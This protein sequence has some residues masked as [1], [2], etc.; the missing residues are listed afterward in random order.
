MADSVDELLK[1]RR[2]LEEKLAL[3]DRQINASAERKAEGIQ[4]LQQLIADYGLS[5]AEIIT[6]FSRSSIHQ[7]ASDTT[8]Q[9]K[10]VSAKYSDG[11]GNTWSGRGPKPKWLT[12]AINRDGKLLSDFL[13]K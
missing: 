6:A 7:N 12:L 4:K 13:I 5:L 1:Q 3:L 8:Q 2:L 10:R 9:R 11:N